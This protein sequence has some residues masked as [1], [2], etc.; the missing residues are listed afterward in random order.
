MK[1]SFCIN[2]FRND[3]L[4]PA[5]YRLAELGY[6]GVEIWQRQ[7]EQNR[8]PILRAAVADAGLRVAQ[9]CPY[10]D[11]VNGPEKIEAS[12]KL[13]E[14]YVQLAAECPETP[15]LV[16]VFTGPLHGPGAVASSACS[17]AAWAAAVAGMRRICQ[18]GA[19]RGVGFALETHRGTLVDTGK[20][21]VQFITDVATPN[22]GANLQV[23]LE[24]EPNPAASARKV[25]PHVVHL[26]A[27]N[28][29]DGKGTFLADGEYDFA[30][31][32]KAVADSGPFD[33]FVSIEHAYHHPVWQTAVV[34]A[35]YLKKLIPTIEAG[36]AKR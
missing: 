11:L 13:A 20:S 3:E 1:S 27:N 5:I 18:I 28:H 12:V 32:L 22:L 4:V 14:Q 33:G 7:M 10:F 30:A 8:W 17:Q 29:K 25:G 19:A 6:Q 16:R 9:L 36:R 35:E 21:I 26:H 34:E 15:A 23:P 24:G 31:F 2:V